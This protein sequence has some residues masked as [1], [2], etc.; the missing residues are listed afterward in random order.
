[1]DFGS[2]LL[3]SRPPIVIFGLE[4]E[5]RREVSGIFDGLWVDTGLTLRCWVRF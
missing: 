1:M 4:L 5:W 3:G 2:R